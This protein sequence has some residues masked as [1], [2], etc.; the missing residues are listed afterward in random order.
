[1]AIF[2]SFFIELRTQFG[3]AGVVIAAC[4]WPRFIYGA[5]ENISFPFEKRAVVKI[6][7]VFCRYEMITG[8]DGNFMFD[9]IEYVVSFFT[10]PSFNIPVGN[11][12]NEMGKAAFAASLAGEFCI[13]IHYVITPD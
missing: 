7:P 6:P 9:Y 2:V 8:P 11:I 10:I 12:G 1:M 5:T 13:F 3:R 4:P